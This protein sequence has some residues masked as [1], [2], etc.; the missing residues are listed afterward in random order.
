MGMSG[1]ESV[2]DASVVRHLAI[3]VAALTAYLFRFE[4]EAGNEVLWV[5]GVAALLNLATF[6]LRG[7]MGSLLTRLSPWL[8]II[9]WTLL[10]HFTGGISS[11]FIAGLALEIVLSALDANPVETLLVTMGA[12]AAVFAQHALQGARDLGIELLIWV[13][14]LL[15]VGGVTSLWAWSWTR[16]RDSIS[17]QRDDFRRRLQSL[18]QE[19]SEQ[20]VLCDMGENAARLAHGLKNAVHS[21]RGFTELLEPELRDRGGCH[22]A[23]QGLNA[24]IDG[25]EK[26]TRSALCGEMDPAEVQSGDVRAAIDRVT[27]EVSSDNPSIHWTKRFLDSASTVSAP[28]AVIREVLGVLIR[29]AVEAMKGSGEVILETSSTDVDFR[30]LVRDRGPGLG[31]GQEEILLRPVRSTKP[32]GSGYGLFLARRL[33]EK[34]GGRLT[35]STAMEGGAQISM[36]LPL[37]HG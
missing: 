30:L 21:L 15:A 16:E 26:L 14:L 1:L 31:S 35:A 33:L 8:G 6:F 23:V 7:R 37:H 27:E 20:Q 13:T 28:S 3:L 32:G 29:N 11:P 17:T 36:T 18:E 9:S 5:L 22:R 10:T 34:Y 4:L 25:L 12:V 2:R 24:A 19:L